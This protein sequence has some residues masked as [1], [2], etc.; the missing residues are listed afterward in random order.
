MAESVVLVT[1]PRE[2]RGSQK[3]RQ[4]RRKGLIPGVV[5]GHKQAAVSIALS[6]EELDNAIRHGARVVD[7]HA[8]KEVQKALIKEIQWDHLGK[9]IVHID[10]ARVAADERVKVMVRI[11][12][13]GIAPGVAAGGVLD[14]PMH[15]LEVECLVSSV[16]ESIRVNI[17]ELQLAQAIHL[18]DVVMPEGVKPL[19][20]PD[21]IVIQVTAPQAEP[22]AP[23]VPGAEQAEPEVIGRQKAEEEEEGA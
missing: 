14:Q 11:E 20:D 19:G 8:G 12:T 5:Y 23:A 17:N 6:A 1:Q 4:L 9:E 7:L 13:R 22:E 15:T 21:A 2:G 18:R 10:F 16:P 3:A